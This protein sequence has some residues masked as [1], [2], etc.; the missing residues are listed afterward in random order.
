MPSVT[1]YERVSSEY[2]EVNG[3]TKYEPLESKDS[4]LKAEMVNKMNNRLF[5]FQP[6]NRESNLREKIK[7]R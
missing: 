6:A 1:I 7:L 4:N 5:F 2:L 3:Y